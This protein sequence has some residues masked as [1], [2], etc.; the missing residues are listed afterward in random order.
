VASDVALKTQRVVFG[1]LDIIRSTN[2]LTPPAAGSEDALNRIWLG[3]FGTWANQKND[4]DVYGYKYR[5]GGFAIG[6]DRHVDS[7]PGLI[8]GISG[9]FS[10][11]KLESDDDHFTMDLKT[12]GFGFY[13]S[14]TASNKFFV[15]ASLAYATSQNEYDVDL[16]LGGKKSG[17]FDITTLQLGT[18]VGGIF[19]TGDFVITPSIGLRYLNYKQKG[20]TERSTNALIPANFF[21]ETSD[22]MLEIPLEVRFQKEIKGASATFIPELRLGVTFVGQK[23]DNAIRVGFAGTNESI[24]IFGSKPKTTYFQGGFGVKIETSSMVDFFINYDLNAA[25]KY[26]DHRLSAGLGFEF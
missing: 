12:A 8:L 14:Y 11:G 23:P 3:G 9:G 21:A 6:Y 4:N 15:D 18:R 2:T 20:F 22:H 7:L 17:D 10:S 13:G 24:E 5:S 25:S 1:R 16:V 26:M 19:E